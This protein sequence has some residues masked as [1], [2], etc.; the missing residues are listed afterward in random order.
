[1]HSRDERSRSCSYNGHLE[2]T[3]G[4]A[5]WPARKE[6][7]A[8]WGLTIPLWLT[9][10]LEYMINAITTVIVGHI[11]TTELNAASLAVRVCVCAPW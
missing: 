8:L 9:Y 2:L 11:G 3:G 7:I 1:M 6:F 10:L 4:C 5:T